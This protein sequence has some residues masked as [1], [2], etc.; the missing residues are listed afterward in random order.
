MQ[1]GSIYA[2]NSQVLRCENEGCKFEVGGYASRANL[3]SHAR[4]CDTVTPMEREVRNRAGRWPR[5]RVA[6]KG[7]KR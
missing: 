5:A 7:R 6:L 4:H 3:R 2:E 1:L